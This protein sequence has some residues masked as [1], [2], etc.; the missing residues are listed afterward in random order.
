MPYMGEYRSASGYADAGVGEL[1][2][3]RRRRGAGYMRGSAGQLGAY[4]GD[5]TPAYVDWTN[6]VSQTGGVVTNWPFNDQYRGQPAARYPM[7]V[8]VQLL[9]SGNIDQSQPAQPDAGT[10]T[11]MYV[12]AGSDVASAAQL[13]TN[14]TDAEAANLP[15]GITGWNPFA[16]VSRTTKL[17]AG[18]AALTAFAAFA[19]LFRRR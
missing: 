18:A 5:A 17:M 11:Y 6:A 10:G 4:L 9:N 7:S 14:V 16:N 8:Y 15:G 12:L 2:A 19:G 1:G 3:Y 13:L